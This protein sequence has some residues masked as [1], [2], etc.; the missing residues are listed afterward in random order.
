MNAPLGLGFR[1]A[2]HPMYA[3]FEFQTREDAASRDLGY[4]FLVAAR[5][6]LAR[7]QNLDVPAFQF[8]VAK[9]HAEKI[10][11]EE[12]RLIAAGSSANFENGVFFIRRV[13]WQK[14]DLQILLEIKE[15][16]ADRP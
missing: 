6:P 9:I 3:G 2:L 13:L 14:R 16:C 5:R 15:P 10:A 1:H 7:R 4:D 12:C 8:G 11:G